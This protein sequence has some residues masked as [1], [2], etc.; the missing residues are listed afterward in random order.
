MMRKATATVSSFALLL[1]ALL[2]S[3]AAPAPAQQP[4]IKALLDA[5][6]E[7]AKDIDRPAWG[8]HAFKR[9]VTRQRLD[10]EGDVEWRQTMLFQVTPTAGGLDEELL[11]MDS[12]APTDSE[13]SKHRKK[14]MFAKHYAQT[15]DVTL[16]NPLGADL[17]LLPLIYEQEHKYVGEEEVDGIPCH[18]IRFDARP[19][20][21]GEPVEVKLRYAMQGELCISKEGKRLM[22]VDVGTVRPV[23]SAVRIDTMRIHFEAR[24]QGDAWLPTLFEMRSEAKAIGMKFNTHN[25]YRYSDFRTVP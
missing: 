17:P 5:S 8:R 25:F 13:K 11:E 20:P 3:T 18:R 15:A 2:V 7:N 19:E 1:C 16:E 12:R 10:E 4:D 24:P 23:K 9:H 21:S 14:G 6:L 22:H